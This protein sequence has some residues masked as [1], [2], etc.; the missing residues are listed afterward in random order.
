MQNNARYWVTRRLELLKHRQNHEEIGDIFRRLKDI[1][2]TISNLQDRK[3]QEG[4]LAKKDLVDLRRLLSS[5]HFLLWQQETLQRQ[6]LR[7]QWIKERDRNFRFFHH[8]TII[9]WHRNQIR[10]IRD[11]KGQWLDSEEDVRNEFVFFSYLGGRLM[12][13]VIFFLHF[14][15]P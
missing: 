1:K 14:R 8:A 10:A 3:D 6:K 4:E 15:T 11:S 9:R 7:L 13:V 12:L 2:A 5:H